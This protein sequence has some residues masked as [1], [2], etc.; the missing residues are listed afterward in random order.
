MQAHTNISFI[1]SI[2]KFDLDNYWS[3]FFYKSLEEKFC[4]N[5]VL[6]PSFEQKL[7]GLTK[8]NASFRTQVFIEGA[9]YLVALDY[10]Q[11]KIRIATSRISNEVYVLDQIES[12]NAT[13]EIKDILTSSTYIE[14]KHHIGEI[15]KINLDQYPGVYKQVQNEFSLTSLTEIENEDLLKLSESITKGLLLKLEDYTPVFF[16]RFSDYALSLTA[17]YAL[18]RVHLLKFLAILPSL[19]HDK[20]GVEVKRIL[21]ESLRR[22]IIDSKAAKKNGLK[23]EM[24]A[25]PTVW[26]SLFYLVYLLANI[27]PAGILARVIR[28][29]VRFMAKRFIAGETIETA[30]KNFN[31]I[32]SSGRD[33]TL[34]QLG[35]LVVSEV[36]ADHYMSEVLKLVEGFGQHINRGEKN[37]AGILRAH[38]SI[39]VSAL[40]SSFKP[41]AF[42]YTYNLVAPRLRKILLTAKANEVFINIDAEHYH[43]RDVVFKVYKK[44]LLE[45]AELRDFP[46]TGIV[47]QAYLRDGA[48]HLKDVVELA[49]LRE[50][51]M[52]VRLVKG[53]YWDA[54]TVEAKANGHLAPQFL[55]KEETDIHFRQM[56]NEIFKS[57]PHIQLCLASHNFSDHAYGVALRQLKYPSLPMI[58]HQ[59]LHM[60]YEALSTALSKMG[61]AVR[62]YVPI[63]S[64]I[65]GMAYL[66]RRIME[67]SSQVGVLT[68]MRSHKKKVKL[69]SPL[70]IFQDN[71]KN[72]KLNHDWVLQNLDGSF[73]NLAPLRTYLDEELST[74]E[75]TRKAIDNAEFEN[76]KLAQKFENKFECHGEIIK[77]TSPSDYSPV[78]EIQFATSNDA[79]LALELVDREFYHGEWRKSH[80]AIKCAI[81]S[82][83][84]LLMTLRRNELSY[85]IMK[86]S[87]KSLKEALGDVDEAVDFINFYIREQKKLVENLHYKAR[88]PA[89]VIAPWNFPLA[90]ACGMTI[91]A[92]VSGASVILKSAEQTPLVAQLLI[93]LLHEAGVPHD[94]LIHLPG[95]GEVV[96]QALIESESVATII[97]TGSKSVGVHIT[98]VAARRMFKNKSDG[99]HYPV[100]VITEMGGKNA[101]IVTSNAEL[102]ETVSGIL[103]SAFGHAGQKCSACSRVIVDNKVKDRLI[104]RLTQAAGDLKVG[105]SD[106]Y[107]IYINPLV[108]IEEKTRLIAQ[109]KEATLEAHE[110]GGKVHLD[111]SSEDLPGNCVG[112]VIIELPKRVAVKVGAFSRREL[113]APVIH[114][115]GYDTLDQ[116]HEIFNST[117]YAL[118]GGVYSQ[119]Q[120]DIDFLTGRMQ[121][122]N[123]YINR[124]ITGARV[125][126]EPFGGFK[127]SGTGPKAGGVDYLK[128]VNIYCEGKSPKLD[129]HIENGSEYSVL[130][131]NPSGL[132]HQ[133]RLDRS[134][135]S[136][137]EV[138]SH[139][140]QLFPGVFGKDKELLQHFKTKLASDFMGLVE[141]NRENRIIPGQLN[142]S[143][144]NSMKAS[145]VVISM[146]D[147]PCIT[148]FMNFFMAMTCGLGVTV[149]C[150][151]HKSFM[152]WKYLI[153][154]LVRNRFSNRNIDCYLVN[155]K[156]LKRAEDQF[157]D[158]FVVDSDE[159]GFEH[160]YNYLESFIGK[161]RIPR[162]V[163]SFDKNTSSLFDL[164]HTYANERS[165][166]IN[167]MRH[168]APMEVGL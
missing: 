115:I 49:K 165:F 142:Y 158:V 148:T 105:S 100:K 129:S 7:I 132:G 67:N 77:I 52:P 1:E 44:L 164:F 73:S 83:A 34:D 27:A 149:L 95:V 168:G 162:V 84:S 82:K 130:F 79:K 140:G 122:G 23:G 26:V 50:M 57:F 66:V 9:E 11:K 118:T 121:S 159:K 28:F 87:G 17:R 135:K 106:D 53:A 72:S 31:E 144:F 97:F 20:A 25:L 60:T 112:P 5:G 99:S 69:L 19:D 14:F 43:Y 45:T 38:V 150:T 138:I 18:L 86:E 81:L 40:C 92:L 134:V 153:D 120:D 126:I 102:D 2:S 156:T 56:I 71:A 166:A 64:L 155:V 29:K 41:E 143:Q 127:L 136:L 98:K 36:E 10:E 61:W 157:V 24:T 128:A 16:E 101:I 145:C 110:N 131:S 116:A 141:K 161:R 8:N 15:L 96:G 104:A 109:V 35:E 4:S 123:I 42:E 55:N 63:G 21:L 12:A 68:I 108:T 117:Q 94:A 80:F 133:G 139:F 125:G 147:R 76:I 167:V 113:F 119:S 89:V 22:L 46:H 111:R 6:V 48:K 107:S 91:S 152:W 54:E 124:P 70:K 146:T 90:I 33:V 151:N 85:L 58:E 30:Q 13:D 78:G 88:G 62:N 65:V 39:K 93:D 137:E 114:I 154:L 163:T 74:F 59:C 160:I 103:Y 3:V 75:K 32:F 47:I 37:K 51:I